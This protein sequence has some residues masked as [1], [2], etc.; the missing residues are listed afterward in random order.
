V[1]DSYVGAG[2]RRRSSPVVT[3]RWLGEHGDIDGAAADQAG[4][5]A[6]EA[7]RDLP[8]ADRLGMLLH[9]VTSLAPAI[10]PDDVDDEDWVEDYLQIIEVSPCTIWFEIGVG[11]IAVPRKA[12]DI[13]R[14][15]WS[16][17]VTAARLA[18]RWHLLEVDVV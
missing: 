18:K 16:V 7:A 8:M 6:R 17:F 10:E 1:R 14:P 3:V 11:P 9:D 5:H 12:S 2:G 15:G 4:E 13:A